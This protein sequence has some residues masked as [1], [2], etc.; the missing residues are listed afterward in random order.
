MSSWM[1]RP[2]ALTQPPPS[3]RRLGLPHGPDLVP[4]RG[5]LGIAIE[6]FKQEGQTLGSFQV[7]A[8]K[9]QG[10]LVGVN[11]WL[12]LAL[13][14][15][16]HAAL[17]MVFHLWRFVFRGLLGCRGRRGCPGRVFPPPPRIELLQELFLVRSRTG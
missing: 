8:V 17:H 1:P 9:L 5:C 10:A 12:V 14:F 11:G 15:V 2:C 16:E 3:A 6:L 4:Q 13:L 7:L